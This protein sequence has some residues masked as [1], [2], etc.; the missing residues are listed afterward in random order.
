M[1][2]IDWTLQNIL[3]LLVAV[4]VCIAFVAVVLG[5]LFFG[6]DA[7]NGVVI[8]IIGMFTALLGGGA[9]VATWRTAYDKGEIKA[10]NTMTIA[11]AL[12]V[13]RRAQSEK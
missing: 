1:N 7:T 4:T 9:S 10:A 5:V 11:Q 13:T 12:E 2:K 6:V 8:A 3:T